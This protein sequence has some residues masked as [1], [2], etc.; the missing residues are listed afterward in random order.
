MVPWKHDAT[1]INKESRSETWENSRLEKRGEENPD[2]RKNMD[3]L[4]HASTY[5]RQTAAQ[6]VMKRQKINVSS[7][8]KRK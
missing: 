4:V 7:I 6:S 5:Q 3:K 1:K 2:R 8:H